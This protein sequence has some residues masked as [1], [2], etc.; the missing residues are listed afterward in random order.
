MDEKGNRKNAGQGSGQGLGRGGG[1]GRNKG[2]AFG[3]GG[4][5]V[6]AACGHKEPHSPG[7]KCTTVKCPECGKP[8][9]RE[10]LLNK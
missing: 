6:C 7:I 4:Y 1:R 8:L 2:G 10:E 3:P 5:C 9:V